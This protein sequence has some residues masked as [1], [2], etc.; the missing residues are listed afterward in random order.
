MLGDDDD[1]TVAILFDD[2]A[3]GSGDRDT[4]LAVDRGQRMTSEKLPVAHCI[5][6]SKEQKGRLPD[7]RTTQQ[8][9]GS[10][11]NQDSPAPI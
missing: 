3:Q 7:R 5:P 1:A 11:K 9:V 2:G 8:P 10:S 6:L 4:A